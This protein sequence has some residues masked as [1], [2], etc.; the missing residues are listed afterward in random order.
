MFEN[1]VVPVDLSSTSL[2]VVPVA[3]RM[4]AEVGGRVD[5]LTV[6]DTL[7]DVPRARAALAE[8]VDRLGPQPVDLGQV[9]QAS[10]SV[11]GAITRHVDEHPGSMVLMSSH[12]HGRAAALLGSTVDDLLRAMF[13]PLVFAAKIP[14]SIKVEEAHAR[15]ESVLSYAP[16]SIGAAAYRALARE[17]T[18]HGQQRQ[19]DRHDDPGGDP[20]AHHA[21]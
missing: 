16:K 10:R 19:A 18:S 2:R 15:H 4:A 21:A 12:G 13:G 3:A 20:A 7:S 14:R 8:A 1:L 6:V 17:I 5:V 11:V 9:V